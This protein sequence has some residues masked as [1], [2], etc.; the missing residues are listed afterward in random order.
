MIKDDAKPFYY[1]DYKADSNL[2]ESGETSGFLVHNQNKS[3]QGNTM[4]SSGSTSSNPKLTVDHHPMTPFFWGS[5]T[6]EA[7]MGAGSNVFA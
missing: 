7:S 3:R 1:F 6:S 5:P 4:L 2:D